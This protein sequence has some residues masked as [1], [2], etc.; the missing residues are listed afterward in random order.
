MPN[1]EALMGS[2]LFSLG[3][4]T[5]LATCLAAAD[6]SHDITDPSEPADTGTTPLGVTT[7]RIAVADHPEAVLWDNGPLVT[8][9]GGGAAGADASAVQTSL[10]MNILG[11]G[12]QWALG[13][14]VADDFTVTDASGWEIDTITFFAYQTGSTT[15]STITGVYV[16]IWDGPP[17]AGGTVI[18]GDQTTNRMQSTGWSNI[19]RV[20]DTTLATTNRPVMANDAAIGTTLAQG[21]YWVEWSTD[22]TLSSGPWAPPV[23]ILGQTAT[24][25][26][27]QYIT[28]WAALT[29]SGTLTPQGMPF[30]IHGSVV[31]PP[32]PPPP[33]A[34]FVIDEVSNDLYSVDLDT[35]SSTL[36]GP[37]SEDPSFSGMAFDPSTQLIFVSDVTMPGGGAWGLGTLDWTNGGI[38]IVGP[39]VNTTDIH[40]LAYDRINNQLWGADTQCAGGSGL[41]TVN[42][43]TGEAVCI[44]NFGT[45]EIRGLAYDQ[46]RDRLYGINATDLVVVDRGTGAAT[47]IGPHGIPS[48]GSVYALEFVPDRF[49]LF[50]TTSTGDLYA[51]DPGN[52]AASLIGNTGFTGASSSAYIHSRAPGFP[53]FPG[54]LHDNGDTDTSTGYSN[55][56][57]PGIPDRRSLLDDFV[58]PAGDASWQ[59]RHFRWRH[60]WN[61]REMPS[62]SGVE[63]RI[64]ANDP[65]GGGAGIDGPGAV[66]AAPPIRFYSETPTGRVLFWRNEML[67]IAEFDPVVLSAGRYWLDWSV[68]GPDNDFVPVNAASI[69]D[70]ECWVDYEDYSGLEPGSVQFGIPADL[71]WAL[72]EARIGIFAHGFEAGSTAGWSASHP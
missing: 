45:S 35:A 19:Y 3:L 71:V 50:A 56:I 46:V 29:D 32:P 4:A 57:P 55:G 41:A 36:I 23:T 59:L 48:L 49:S 44:G 37:T 2:R 62:G 12:H 30:I 40:A 14:S 28:A 6:P 1:R 60:F 24:G 22:G 25:N 8:H 27:L 31:G 51:V 13:Y 67:S 38:G 69:H 39:H 17:D 16:R 70:N 52:G 11:F 7:A 15:A 53:P 64:R 33:G 20:N 9:P 21:T 42:R 47:P 72:G 61:T 65:N 34:F 58:V 18:W 54:T 5:V 26:A 68:I 63:L 10:G 66:L 43:T